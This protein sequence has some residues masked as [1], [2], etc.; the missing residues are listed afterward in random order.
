M[1]FLDI[2]APL[3]TAIDGALK[4]LP[5]LARLLIWAVVTAILSMYLY[6]LCS[7]Q[8]K[9]GQAKE[10]A[11]AARQKMAGYDGHEFGEMWPLAKESLASSGKHFLVVLGPAVLSS[12]PAL[13]L[14]I[15]VSGQFSYTLPDAGTAVSVSAIPENE[16][17]VSEV[18][19]PAADAPAELLDSNGLSLLLLPLEAAV[20]VV[21]KRLWWNS[22]IG[23]PNGY[24]SDDASVTEV[25]FELAPISYLSFGPG[26]VRGWELTYFLV[27]VICSLGIKVAFRIH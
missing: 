12:V 1:G 24:L 13:M 15:W 14:I 10:R 2:P 17:S 23:N 18:S 8:E 25:H 5:P 4:S 20:P 26:W 9:V 3:F 21:H 27:L 19:W 22:V 7:A 6:W 11:I 16:L